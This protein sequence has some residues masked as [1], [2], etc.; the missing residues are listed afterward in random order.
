MAAT[1]AKRSIWKRRVFRAATALN[2]GVSVALAVALTLLVNALAARFPVRADFSR[3]R[4]YSLSDK[5]RN[6][7][8][9]L[10]QPLAVTALVETDFELFPDIRSLLRECAAAGPK[11]DIR[12]VDPDRDLGE[13]RALARRYQ[14]NESNVLVLERG[15]RM[16][17]IDAR[18]MMDYNYW[19]LV[20]GR[21]KTKTA[22]RGEQLIV[23]AIL[24]LLRTTMPLV[25][26]TM[27]HGEGDVDQFS[28]SGYSR[29]GLSVRRD[30][31]RPVKL[32]VESGIPDDCAVVVALGPTRPFR[33][34]AVEALRGFLDR[35]GRALILLESGR[36]SGL[37]PLLE[38][39]GVS[40]ESG[41]VA[42]PALTGKELLVTDFA[43][44]PATVQLR[45]M[46]CAFYAPR[47]VEP[48]PEGSRE[49]RLKVTVLAAGPPKGWLETN[50]TQDPPRYDPAEDRLGA[51][52]LAV[53]VEQA[54]PP[55]L[56]TPLPAA[57]LVVIGDADFVANG[58]LA[59][60]NED[61]FMGALNW[62]LE[63]D[64]LAA[65]SPRAPDEIRM[66]MN[67]G[68]RR[69]L[70]L[71]VVAGFPG[72]ALFLAFLVAVVRRR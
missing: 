66:D 44:H 35:G 15:G 8:R 58:A 1:A 61:V 36:R 50:P 16:A 32:S 26:F 42:G 49:D 31:M 19:P 37:E 7:L 30:A 13:A 24:G 34:P 55:G 57:R 51:I 17:V 54:L 45:N 5:T 53:A 68:Q 71:A 2:V 28:A 12:F 63:R 47:S 20:E 64:E 69:L 46:A 23:S 3:A 60:G 33:P 27:G 6:L 29:L 39:W 22:F 41:T 10:D 11:L 65:V 40:T 67:A 43:D 62:L 9:G 21:A 18:K 48:M 56:K 52:P 38:S 4:Y 14:L 25:G 72:A 59:G 70:F